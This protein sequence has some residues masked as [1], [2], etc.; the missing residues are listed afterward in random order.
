MPLI[1]R[2]PLAAAPS[3][4]II[5][6]EVPPC[7]EIV[8]RL[9]AFPGNDFRRDGHCCRAKL[10]GAVDAG[11]FRGHDLLEACTL[12]RRRDS[13]LFGPTP[14]VFRRLFASAPLVES[15]QGDAPS[16]RN[17][18]PASAVAACAPIHKNGS[19]DAFPGDDCRRDSDCWRARQ[20]G[21][22]TCCDAAPSLSFF[23][24]RLLPRCERTVS[25]MRSPLRGNCGP[26]PRVCRV[27]DYGVR[28]R[29]S[30]SAP[31]HY[32]K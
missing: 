4:A 11:Y 26:P 16:A 12:T 6:E 14:C 22:A 32:S 23:A 24:A 27:L 13:L 25:K 10:V 19:A 5:Q 2:C 31:R 7:G 21:E 18:R 20:H 8:A 30:I 15:I 9:F 3:R 1:F 17:L 29:S 28:A